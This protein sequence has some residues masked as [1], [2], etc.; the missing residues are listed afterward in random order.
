LKKRLGRVVEEDVIDN[1]IAIRLPVSVQREVPYEKIGPRRA[2]D[3]CIARFCKDIATHDRDARGRRGTGQFG[4]L[5]LMLDFYVVA[6]RVDDQVILD[7]AIE[8]R[9]RAVRTAEVHPG[10]CTDDDIVSEDPSP[11]RA[12]GR[13]GDDVL[14]RVMVND[15]QVLERDVMHRATGALGLDPVNRKMRAVDSYVA[16]RDVAR[17]RQAYGVRTRP[18]K[19]YRGVAVARTLDND[20]VIGSTMQPM[21]RQTIAVVARTQSEDI[22]RLKSCHH[23]HIRFGARRILLSQRSLGPEERHEN[24]R[25]HETIRSEAYRQVPVAHQSRR[26][27]PI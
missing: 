25:C 19:Q 21:Q 17:I 16:N 7:Q 8:K 27:G 6:D 10:A 1:F 5:D 20:R 2:S 12:L 13:D 18:C 24:K 14:G 15:G 11:R 3:R 4:A 23:G 9:S 26:I 22:A